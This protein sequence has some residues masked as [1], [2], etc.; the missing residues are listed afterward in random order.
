MSEEESDSAIGDEGIEVLI[1]V[2]LS[3][4]TGFLST[5]DMSEIQFS[6]WIFQ[7]RKWVLKTQPSLRETRELH[8]LVFSKLQFFHN[9][10][11]CCG[12]L[13]N[14]HTL[15]CLGSLYPFQHE[16]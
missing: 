13:A 8:L 14:L 7:Q 3:L 10:L 1:A 4:H 9:L 16:R 11:V 2:A 5:I 15:P 6:L 12:V